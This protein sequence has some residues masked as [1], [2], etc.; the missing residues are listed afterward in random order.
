ML[1]NGGV[2]NS[3]LLSE[4]VLS[5]FS[6]WRGQP[7][8]ELSNPHPDL[9]VAYGAVAYAKARHGAQLKIG[10][11]SARSFFLV[12]EGKKKAK[13]GLCI[14]PKGLDEGTEIRLKDRKFALTL[15]EPVRFNLMSSTDDTH[16]QAGGLYTL[17]ADSFVALPPFI[18]TLDSETDRSELAANQKDR[19]EVTLACQLTEVG[20]LQI[21]CVSI[22]DENKRWKVEFAIRKDIAKLNQASMT[23]TGRVCPAR[24][25][26]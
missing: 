23:H 12:L 25:H 13:Q 22:H 6:A 17:D 20:T 14:L 18:A 26:G 15:G 2:F 4:R 11:G 16:T 10:G 24:S 21:E 8:A 7:V 5:T 3:P 19:E 9:A 1:L